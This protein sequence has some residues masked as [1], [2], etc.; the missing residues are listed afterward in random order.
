MFPVL[1][2]LAALVPT[3]TLPRAFGGVTDI[4]AAQRLAPMFGAAAHRLTHAAGALDAEKAEMQQIMAI[5]Q[6]IIARA[7]TDLVQLAQHYLA[8]VTRLAPQML[9]PHPAQHLAAAQAL[10]ALSPATLAA[11]GQRTQ[12]LEAELAQPTAQLEHIAQ[13]SPLDLDQAP[14]SAAGGAGS[15][16]ASTSTA[17]ARAVAAAE[18][19]LGTPYVWGGTTP[20]GFDCSGLVQWSY[21]QAGVELPRMAHEQAVGRQVSADELQLGDL[22]VWDGHVAMYAGEGMM[23][24]A[25]DPVQKNPVRTTNMGM[26]FLGFYRPTY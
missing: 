21:A 23:I 7:S 12:Q 13:R 3:A 11:A 5:A 18:S 25:G 6:P 1:T 8:D 20:D 19:Q 2:Q 16:T 26:G 14:D 22:V 24:E 9:S 4:S 17:G 10:A 15:G